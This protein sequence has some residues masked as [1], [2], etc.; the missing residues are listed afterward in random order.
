LILP[1]F[2]NLCGNCDHKNCCTDSAVPLVFSKELEIIKKNHSQYVDYL[3]IVEINGISVNAIKKKKN[4]TECIFWDDSTGGCKIY[5]S[6]PMDCRM[7]PF[8]IHYIDGSYH[9]I[10]YSCNENSDWSWS[11]TELKS[12]E[13]HAGFDDLMKNIDLFSEHTNMILP[14]ESKKTPYVVL[15]KVNWENN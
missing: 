5:E 7:Y 9:W 6:R 8:D 11:E 14:R 1:L 12:L 4:L 10:V 13:N 3:Q 2:E 15:R